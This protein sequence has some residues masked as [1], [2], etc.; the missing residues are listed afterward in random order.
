M[1]SCEVRTEPDG[2]NGC[3]IQSFA[4]MEDSKAKWYVDGKDYMAAVADAID[5]AESEILITDWKF[6]PLIFLKRSNGGE[7]RLDNV[8]I[9]KVEGKK[10]EG[11]DDFRI[12]ILLYDDPWGKLTD[13]R[14]A[15]EHFVEYKKYIKLYYHRPMLFYT[16]HEKVVV[17][18]RSIAF[19]G[20]IDLCYGRWDTHDHS[21]FDNGLDPCESTGDYCNPRLKK[22]E[23]RENRE[24]PR[25]PWH[26]VSCAFTG[27]A[28]KDVVFHFIQRYKK[29][30]YFEMDRHAVVPHSIPS[31]Y[32]LNN[33]VNVQVLRSVGFQYPG[34]KDKHIKPESS[35]HEA[36]C[37]VIRSAKQYIYIENQFFISSQRSGEYHVPNVDNTIQ[38][39]LFERIREA[40][41]NGDEFHVFIVLPIEP[42]N[43]KDDGKHTSQWRDSTLFTGKDSLMQ[44]LEQDVNFRDEKDQIPCYVSIYGLR[45]HVKRDEKWFTEIIYVHS[46]VMIADDHTTIIGSAN[47]NDRSMIGDC[48]SEVDVIIKDKDERMIDSELEEEA[49][50]G[51]FSKSL[52]LH[53]FKEHFGLP[54]D[55]ADVPITEEF[56]RRMRKRATKNTKIYDDLIDPKKVITDD[57]V[58][59]ITG[60][61]VMF[62]LEL[63]KMV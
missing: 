7:K 37:S 24:K 23:Q 35:I 51:N 41:K 6:D 61:H 36:Y 33:E 21:L 26:D 13:N 50:V 17:V 58:N 43:R 5:D 8:L 31:R 48:D 18:D 11:K 49:R 57:D 63:M 20:G 54:D 53:L 14:K 60:R 32:G 39:E 16:H 55:E 10:K 45:T 4:S 12:H 42:D 34:R 15:K 19:V 2:A 40:K 62:P 9:E 28:V 46:K 44:K 29:S 25:M 1:A 30:L 52:R 56:I 3:E 22:Q 47:I 38:D 59:S 27:K